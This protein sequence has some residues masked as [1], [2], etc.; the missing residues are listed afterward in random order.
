MRAWLMAALLV[1]GAAACKK[2]SDGEPADWTAPPVMERTEQQRG[3]TACGAYVERLCACA[4]TD[5]SLA[6]QCKLARTQPEALAQL[7]G[8]LNGAEG[9]LGKRE[10][11]ETQHTAR[12]IIQDCFEKDAALDPKICPRP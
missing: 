8:M 7:L 3:T 5:T 2:S 9:K 4:E 1:A 11:R 6:E 12:K 10:L